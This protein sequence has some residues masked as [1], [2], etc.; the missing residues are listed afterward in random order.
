MASAQYGINILIGANLEGFRKALR[1]SEA[2][3]GRLQDRLG[4]MAAISGAAFTGLAVPVGLAVKAFAELEAVMQQIQ[5]VSGVSAREL[6]TMKRVALELGAATKFSAREAALG[7]AELAMAGFSAQQTVA[8]IPGVMAL[9]AAGGVSVAQAAEL[10]GGAL[11]GFG[12][13]AAQATHVADIFAQAATMSA[14]GINDLQLSMK[15]IAPVARGANQSIEGMSTALAILGNQ[16]I[17]GEQAGT[18]MRAVLSRL[19]DPPKEAADAINALKLQLVD[20]SGKMLP[21]AT[22]LDQI[23]EKTKG[24]SD[25]QRTATMAQLAGTEAMSGLLALVST[26][27]KDYDATAAAMNDVNDVAKDMAETMNKGLGPAWEQLAGSVESLAASWGE[28]FA[29]AAEKTLGAI[30]GVVD[31]AAKAP[32]ILQDLSVGFAAAGLAASGAVAAISSLGFSAL[33]LRAA[34]AALGLTLGPVGWAVT[35]LGIAAGVATVAMNRKTEASGKS[36]AAM[37]REQAEVNRLSEELAVLEGKTSLAADEENRRR[38]ILEKIT[39]LAP[40]VVAGINNMGQATEID[41]ARLIAW[42]AEAER[43]IANMARI[44]QEQREETR[45]SIARKKIELQDLRGNER[46]LRREI[47]TGNQSRGFQD[48]TGR[49]ANTESPE[50]RRAREALDANRER[51]M[52]LGSSLDAEEAQYLK[53][54]FS[55]GKQFGPSLPPAAAAPFRPVGKVPRAR[56]GGKGRSGGNVAAVANQEFRTTKAAAEEAAK[57][58]ELVAERETK[59][60]LAGVAVRLTA[61]DHEKAMGILGQRDY[62]LAVEAAKARELDII[63]DAEQRKLAIQEQKVAAELRSVQQSMAK[64]RSAQKKKGPTG[65]EDDEAKLVQQLKGFSVQRATIEDEWLTKRRGLNKETQNAIALDV[66]KANDAEAALLVDLGDKRAEADRRAREAALARLPL[67]ERERAAIELTHEEEIARATAAR[68]AAY[69][70]A[71]RLANL[72]EAWAGVAKQKAEAA[73]LDFRMA[74]NAADAKRD[75]DIKDVADKN[76]AAVKKL[77][78]ALMALAADPS[79]ERIANFA[80]DLASDPENLERLRSEFIQLEKAAK[81]AGGGIEG[82]GAAMN[83]LVRQMDPLGNI[84]IGLASFAAIGNDIAA[85]W[86]ATARHISDARDLAVETLALRAQLE[87]DPD[88]AYDAAIQ[89]IDKEEADAIQKVK[90]ENSITDVSLSS[91]NP[92]RDET[93][94]FL[95]DLTAEI[96]DNANAKREAALKALALA[97]DDRTSD[98]QDRATRANPD[99]AE[100]ARAISQITDQNQQWAEGLERLVDLQEELDEGERDNYGEKISIAARRDL[101]LAKEA[102]EWAKKKAELAERETKAVAEKAKIEKDR[103]KAIRDIENGSIA[104]R[105]KSEAQT[106]LEAIDKVRSDAGEKLTAQDAVIAKL[107]DERTEQ[108]TN[109]NERTAQ[110]RAQAQERID[111]IARERGAILSTLDPLKAELGYYQDI[112]YYAEKA[113]RARLATKLSDLDKGKPSSSGSKA[114]TSTSLAAGTVRANTGGAGNVV[115]DGKSWSVVKR[116]GG[117]DVPG[118]AGQERPI[119]ALGGEHVYT[120]KQHAENQKLWEWIRYR[121]SVPTGGTGG[122]GTIVNLN[123]DIVVQGDVGR[124]PAGAARNFRGALNREL[125]GAGHHVRV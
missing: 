51:Q 109:H 84:S 31:A 93:Q 117:G 99:T 88:K 30:Q 27:K 100:R 26:S 97:R 49:Y 108:Q 17:K 33:A 83:L 114:S 37:Q 70:E 79:L 20:T 68:D 73:R 9:A 82:A 91:Q 8:A 113:A 7:M 87:N 19:I 35:A 62:L 52:A 59:A 76:A 115:W 41:R 92:F 13:D 96:K 45:R 122:G 25:A 14:I 23:R 55:T 69:D 6:E 4:K 104:S 42:N 90:D 18:T 66:K 103:D 118:P 75:L 46:G 2:D 61:I 81:D 105:A 56:G 53:E 94:K 34:V 12:L 36:S 107:K 57:V 119:V 110:I 98:E 11:R 64:I 116:H 111:A 72:G 85:S 40:G 5:A 1:D 54:R 124:N 28:R 123:G 120:A 106:K 121:P 3:V 74:E 58:A 101:D 77:Q 47:E 22:I 95:D 39:A 65:L 10:A 32:P 71:Q 15:Y 102:T 16:M 60:K 21:L 86:K 43:R 67:H 63:A 44:A 89:K 80:R 24:M 112:A 125:G 50:A 29:P 78:G 48:P 38:V